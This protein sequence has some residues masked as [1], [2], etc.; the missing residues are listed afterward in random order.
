VTQP[1]PWFRPIFLTFL[2]ALLAACQSMSAPSRFTPE[3]IAALQSEG[4]IETDAGWELTLNERLLFPI[5]ES[6]LQ[7][8]QGERIAKLA[9]H[10]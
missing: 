5:D 8:G 6:R 7:P 3:Q 9:G 1:R 2:A 4:F 10:L